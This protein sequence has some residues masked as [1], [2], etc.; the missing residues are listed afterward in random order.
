VEELRAK[1]DELEV[2]LA[3][4]MTHGPESTVG[5]RAT[6]KLMQHIQT[7]Q[8]K[9]REGREIKAMSE[10]M[11]AEQA[12]L[13]EQAEEAKFY[14]AEAE[15]K[16]KEYEEL[17]AKLWGHLD[18]AGIDVEANVARP[19]PRQRPKFVSGLTITQGDGMLDPEVEAI[20]R[21]LLEADED[22]SELMNEIMTEMV[23]VETAEARRELASAKAEAE[24]L[25][26]R[27]AER[28]G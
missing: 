6:G 17:S 20:Q 10:T 21:K 15:A 3:E 8:E 4:V 2:T 9:V 11:L 19:T 1:V 14:M 13:R 23:L 5:D 27:L 7:L 25:R 12:L 26:R 24:E 18:R 22:L 28:G 16:A